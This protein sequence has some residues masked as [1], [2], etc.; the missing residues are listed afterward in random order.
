VPDGDVL[1]RFTKWGGAAHWT[2]YG[3]RLGEDRYGVW[4]AAPI[5]TQLTKPGSQFV[6]ARHHA[7]LFP[8]DLPCTAAFY[9]PLPGD[10][11]EQIA[12]YVDITT[13]PV[14]HD[15]QVTM[16]DL[17][18]DVILFGDGT[19]KV[20]DEDEF[21]QHQVSLGYPADVVRLATD[22]CAARLSEV[23]EGQEP[24]GDVGAAWLRRVVE[25]F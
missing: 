22:S 20:D 14:W 11:G 16:V 5:G 3:H 2:M 9:L 17:D 12:T 1:V 18:L 19:V 8:R 15:S 6:A 23:R 4:V 25:A 10:D 24:Y 21:A 7:M 13:I